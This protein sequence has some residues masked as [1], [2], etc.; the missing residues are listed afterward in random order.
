MEGVKRED[1]FVNEK[2][3]ISIKHNW[4]LEFFIGI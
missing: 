1:L 3:Q 2:F 4:N